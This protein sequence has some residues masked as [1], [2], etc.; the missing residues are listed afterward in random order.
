[1]TK[2]KH[3]ATDLETIF[4]N[5]KFHYFCFGDHEEDNV[6]CLQK[7]CITNNS[8][9]RVQSACYTA[10]IFRSIDCDCHEQLVESL[11]I[12]A[13]EGGYFIYMLC[14]GRGAGIYKRYK[15]LN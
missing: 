15:D 14:D 2:Y 4:G 11:K 1:M 13:K 12:I 6:L 5:F 8:L 10:E 7:N 3:R 9:V